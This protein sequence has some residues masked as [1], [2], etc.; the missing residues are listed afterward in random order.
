M[1]I[2][3]VTPLTPEQRTYYQGLLD[4]ANKAY[5]QL[6]TGGMARVV[7]DQNGE[8]VEFT[9]SRRADLYNYILQL[10]GILGTAVT[11]MALPRGPASFIF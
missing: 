3:S 11:P 9:A 2:Q 10:Q 7:V 1:I 6:I 5:H 4:E 8:R